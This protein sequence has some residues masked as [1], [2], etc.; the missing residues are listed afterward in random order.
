MIW[1][2]PTVNKYVPR[3]RKPGYVYRRDRRLCEDGR[4]DCSDVTTG[5][6]MPAY[7]RESIRFPPVASRGNS[8]SHLDFSSIRLR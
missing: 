4:R 2:D 1:V 5:Q 8:S 7:G 6:G 3:R